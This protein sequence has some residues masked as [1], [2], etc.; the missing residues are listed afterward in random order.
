[1]GEKMVSS[2]GDSGKAVAEN[3]KNYQ[4]FPL[5]LWMYIFGYLDYTSLTRVARVSRIFNILADD[6]FLWK[7]LCYSHGF[8]MT[9]D[10]FELSEFDSTIK[11]EDGYNDTTHNN[12]LDSLDTLSIA[13]DDIS[14]YLIL[15]LFSLLLIVNLTF[16]CSRCRKVLVPAC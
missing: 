5:E 1:M 2:K 16:K 9:H 15:Y 10:A 7:A 11:R 14:V 4:K 12:I 3:V 13:S 6:L 8:K